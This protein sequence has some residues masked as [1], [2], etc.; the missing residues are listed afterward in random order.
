VHR[1]IKDDEVI[2]Y[3]GGFGKF[4]FIS[5]I[6]IILGMSSGQFFL[7]AV[8][9]LELYPDYECLDSVNNIWQKCEREQFCSSN[10]TLS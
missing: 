10:S 9:F 7:N 4:Q 6:A 1:Y 2:D 5:S 3:C 8:A